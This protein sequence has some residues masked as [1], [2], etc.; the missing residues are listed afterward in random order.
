MIE[1]VKRTYLLQCRDQLPVVRRPRID[2]RHGDVNHRGRNIRA[3]RLELDNLY[4]REATI[5]RRE[6]DRREGEEV[7][8]RLLE[9]GEVPE[10]GDTPCSIFIEETGWDGSRTI[11]DELQVGRVFVPLVDFGDGVE[12][13]LLEG[14]GAR[15][16]VTLLKGSGG[17]RV[18]IGER[19]HKAAE[20]QQ[21]DKYE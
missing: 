8:G 16:C 15:I 20:E 19:D 5:G 3:L 14:F 4:L 21:S 1:E 13:A 17:V 7:L 12:V 11:G 2:H 6:R 10:G 18:L 9:A